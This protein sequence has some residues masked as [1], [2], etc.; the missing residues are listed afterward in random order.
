MDYTVKHRKLRTGEITPQAIHLRLVAA[1]KATG[2]N[3]RQLSQAA[4]ITYST[5]KTQEAAGSPSLRMLDF[6][7][8]EHGIDANVIMGGDASRLPIEILDQIVAHL[9]DPESTGSA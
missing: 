6:Y 1:R 7:W 8:K 2:L 4:G 9:D 3:A 5:F